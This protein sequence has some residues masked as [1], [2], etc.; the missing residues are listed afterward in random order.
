MEQ[1]TKGGDKTNQIKKCEEKREKK[2]GEIA[3]N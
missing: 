1:E 3:N 2:S